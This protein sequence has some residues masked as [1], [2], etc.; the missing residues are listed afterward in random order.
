MTSLML[1]RK[2]STRSTVLKKFTGESSLNNHM[3]FLFFS[4][5]FSYHFQSLG[6]FITGKLLR[7]YICLEYLIPAISNLIQFIPMSSTNTMILNISHDVKNWGE[8]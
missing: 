3:F 5:L 6:E 2:M 7:E 1:N 8:Y 4:S